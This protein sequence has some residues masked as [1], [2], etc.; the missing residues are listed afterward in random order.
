MAQRPDGFPGTPAS[1]IALFAHPDDPEFVAGGLIAQ[2]TDAGCRVAYVIMTDGRAG[3]AGLGDAHVDP[4]ELVL[5]HNFNKHQMK[6]KLVIWK[7]GGRFVYPDDQDIGKYVYPKD[8]GDYF[9]DDPNIPF[10]SF[11]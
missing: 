8:Y 4:N 10:P 9:T 6:F 3:A 5:L 11:L 7:V 2:W 1:A